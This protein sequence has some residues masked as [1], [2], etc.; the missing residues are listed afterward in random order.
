MNIFYRIL[1]LVGVAAVVAACGGNDDT[2]NEDVDP[3]ALLE[4]AATELD[5]TDSFEIVLGTDGAPVT[6]NAGNVGLDIPITLEGAE[7]AFVRP[8]AL[9]GTVKVL[10]E[11]IAADVDIAIIGDDQYINQTLITFGNWQLMTFLDDFNPETLLSGDDSIQAALRA[12]ENITYEGQTDL[13]GLSVHHVRGEVAAA[14]VDAVTVG[15]IGTDTGTIV[16][17]AYIRTNDN[18]LEQLVVN[19]PASDTNS[20]AVTWTIGLYNYNGDYEV[21]RPKVGAE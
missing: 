15:L 10:L 8:D 21:T 16:V 13:D 1:I 20:G 11:D 2:S 17:D 5:N 3:Q 6:L 19:E 7:G 18:R 9:G 14:K 4:Q 12:F